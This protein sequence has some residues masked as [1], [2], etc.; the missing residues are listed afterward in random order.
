MQIGTGF[1]RQF[2]VRVSLAL[3][4][5]TGMGTV[6]I[7]WFPRD[8]HWNGSDNDYIMGKRMG[9]GVKVWEWE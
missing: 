7:P 4:M 8:S 3:E 1:R 2:L 6:G 9:V 5:C